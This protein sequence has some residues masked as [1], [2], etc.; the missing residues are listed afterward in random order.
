METEATPPSQCVYYDPETNQYRDAQDHSFELLPWRPPVDGEEPRDDDDL[1]SPDNRLVFASIWDGEDPADLLLQAGRWLNRHASDLVVQARQWK[2]KPYTNTA[3]ACF[4]A[5][6][7]LNRELHRSHPAEEFSPPKPKPTQGANNGRSSK[8][9]YHPGLYDYFDENG[10]RVDV[11]NGF[12]PTGDE[13]PLNDEALDRRPVF[14]FTWEGEDHIDILLK[15]AQWLN[16]Y[17]PHKVLDCYAAIIRLDPKWMTSYDR[18]GHFLMEQKKFEEAIPYFQKC[19]ELDPNSGRPYEDTSMAYY[20]L[21]DKE[22]ALLFLDKAIQR[23]SRKLSLY[24]HKLRWLLELK[25]WSALTDFYNGHHDF[26]QE[27]AE[28]RMI[29]YLALAQLGQIEEARSLFEHETLKTKRRFAALTR[30]LAPLVGNT[31]RK[32]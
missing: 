2:I 27:A 9:L 1:G 26:I 3:I 19:I 10:V 8:R 20:E 31:Y 29:R 22:N 7:Q 4:Q 30:E 11:V 14:R 28:A 12:P 15:A 18:T 13:V 32:W 17:Y 23:E 21:G 6:A 5:A 25:R 24:L 16:A